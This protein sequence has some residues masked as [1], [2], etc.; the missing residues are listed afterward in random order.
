MTLQRQLLITI[1]VLFLCLFIG[2][3]T[4]SSY[5]TRTYLDKQLATHARDAAT[6]LGLMLTSHLENNDIGSATSI[7]DAVFDRGYYDAIELHDVD[8]KLVIERKST[9]AIYRV[10][11]WFVSMMALQSPVEKA[12]VNSGWR[13]AGTIT[14][15]SHPGYAYQELWMMTVVV[16]FWF[17][18]LSIILFAL[19]VMAIQHLLRPISAIAKQ[20]QAITEGHFPIQDQ[21]PKTVQLR[22]VVVAMNRMTRKLK[23][24]FDDHRRESTKLRRQVYHDPVTDL[25]NRLYFN[26][27]ILNDITLA[28]DKVQGALLMVQI[29]GLHKYNEINGF[30]AG[31]NIIKSVAKILSAIIKDYD[32]AF[33]A[34][35]TGATFGLV[36]LHVTQEKINALAETVAN[37]ILELARKEGEEKILVPSIGITHLQQGMVVSDVLASADIAL[38]VAHDA[39]EHTFNDSTAQDKEVSTDKEWSDIINYIIK[40]RTATLFVQPAYAADKKS[41]LYKE[42]LLRAR[43]QEEHV[44]SG[45]IL[46]PMAERLKL[47]YKLDRMVIEDALKHIASSH[48]DAKYAIN[49]TLNSLQQENFLSWIKGQL[50]PLGEKAKNVIFEISE[51]IIVEHLELIKNLNN[52]LQP[53]GPEIAIDHFGRALSTFAYLL[54]NRIAYVKIDGS[55]IRSINNNEENQLYIQSLMRVARSI[56]ILVIAEKVETELE[57]ETLFDLGV[58]GIQGI[59][60]GNAEPMV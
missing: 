53:L 49:L 3:F 18:C 21:L 2:T 54:G 28:D 22:K 60:T 16:F 41:L 47:A 36:V 9:M 35:V 48:D 25:Y 37:R 42:I 12:E 45:G 19:G 11:G 59:Y 24:M 32:D 46:F 43:D 40:K 4:I 14:V 58:D 8:G 57:F 15:R 31:D 6:S 23:A 1:S 34:R 10:P 29:D 27:H 52:T 17:L 51:N 50:T 55:F 30:L 44:R 26:N 13:Q 7:V 5:L 20:A 56:D 39:E 38:R 33:V